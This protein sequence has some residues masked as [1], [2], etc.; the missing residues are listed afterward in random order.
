MSDTSSISETVRYP[1][2][3][4]SLQHLYGERL[5]DVEGNLLMS[6]STNKQ[7]SVWSSDLKIAFEKEGLHFIHC[8]YPGYRY[9]VTSIEQASQFYLSR[10]CGH[11][12]PYKHFYV[13][14][15][16]DFDES[17]M[18]NNKN[19][20]YLYVNSSRHP[21]LRRRRRGRSV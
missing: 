19:V 8:L 16:E 10:E 11:E 1:V 5:Y 4:S 6:Q 9:F 17:M 7:L 20:K 14:M 3:I 2:T 13:Y 18:Y 21:P 15:D 12:K